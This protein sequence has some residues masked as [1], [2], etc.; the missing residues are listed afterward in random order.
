MRRALI[1]ASLILAACAPNREGSSPAPAPAL[2]TD[3][4][5]QAQAYL[6]R[7]Q[8][9]LRN[10]MTAQEIHYSQQHRYAGPAEDVNAVAALRFHASE[11]V[12]VRILEASER[13]WSGVATTDGLPGRGCAVFVGGVARPRTA[14]G[15]EV[16]EEGVVVCD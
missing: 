9:D 14:G 1:L 2:A 15:Q 4:N 6:R 11:E 3:P 8:S 16:G 12:Q 10:L 13:G 5:P 7:M